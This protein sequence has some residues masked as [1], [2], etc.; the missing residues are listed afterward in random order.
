MK[1]VLALILV[2]IVFITPSVL[3]RYSDVKSITSIL[4]ID[5]NGVATCKGTVKPYDFNTKSTVK[6]TL[7]QKVGSAWIPYSSWNGSGTGITGAS[8][9]GTKQV[10]KGYSYKVV[11]IGEIKDSNGNFLEQATKESSPVAY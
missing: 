6:V 4:S 3:A 10:A 5:S 9:G 11:T 1:K 8:A 2:L 7:M